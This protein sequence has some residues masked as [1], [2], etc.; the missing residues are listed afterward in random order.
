[1]DPRPERDALLRAKWD[2]LPDAARTDVQ[3]AGRGGVSCGATHGV[4]ERCDLA[5][6][7]CYLTPIANRTPPLAFEAVK[8]QL[9]ALRAALGPGGKAQITAGE[10]T[11][12]PLEQLGRI[13]S[14]AVRIGLDPMLMTNGQRLVAEPDYLLTLVRDHGLRKVSFHVD[15]TQRGRPELKGARRERDLNPVRDAQAELLRRVRR[16]TGAAL[17]GAITMTVTPSSLDQ[18]GDVVDWAR[19]NAD[20]ARI[21]SFQPAAEVGRTRDGRALEHGAP[22]MDAL[23][24]RICAPFGRPLERHALHFG[25]PEC[26]VT[27]PVVSVT[28]GSEPLTFEVVRAG[29][30]R[31]RAA[32]GRLMAAIANRVDSAAPPGQIALSLLG[33]LLRRPRLLGDALGIGLR[34]TWHERRAVARILAGLLR[35]K[36]LTLRPQLWVIHRFMDADELATP[37]GRERLAACVFKLS[38]GGELVSMCEMNATDLRLEQNREARGQVA[39]TLS[40]R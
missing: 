8:A 27:V 12:L 25:H 36:H 26:N 28:V 14:Y 32:F 6:T 1:M 21:V 11:L 9:D 22:S 20:V 5:C 39:G 34:R 40:R 37:L 16:E 15:L 19:R 33:Q 4:L 2:S 7:S 10:V 31:D 23:W 38:V 29:S 30:A 3:L 35:F 24:E 18:V 13:V 17:H